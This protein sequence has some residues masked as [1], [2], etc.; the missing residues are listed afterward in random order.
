VRSEALGQRKISNDTIG[1]RKTYMAV[2]HP[3]VRAR[4]PFQFGITQR[5]LFILKFIN[6]FCYKLH[7]NKSLRHGRYLRVCSERVRQVN[8]S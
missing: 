3:T 4:A 2:S 8:D 6:G 1:N 5:V 7:V